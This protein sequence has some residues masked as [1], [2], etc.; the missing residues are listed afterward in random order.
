M[1]RIV[2][3][4]QI[5]NVTRVEL[6][7]VLTGIR[8]IT[9]QAFQGDKFTDLL[10]VFERDGLGYGLGVR[11]RTIETEW[12]LDRGEFGWDGAGGTYI[13]IDPKQKIS[14]VIGMH[15]LNWPVIFLKK[16]LEIVKSIY[17]EL[18]LEKQ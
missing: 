2:T 5:S 15:I 3:T 12:G 18:F 16:H 17:E 11:V 6:F 10:N 7:K 14:V 13:M 8:T 1:R 9:A 4:V